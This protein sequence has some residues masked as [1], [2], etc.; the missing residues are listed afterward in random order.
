MYGLIGN[1]RREKLVI[2]YRVIALE[3]ICLYSRSLEI[4]R[5]IYPYGTGAACVCEMPGSFKMIAD[6]Q[7]IFY[8][9]SIFCHL[10]CCLCNIIFLVAYRAKGKP[11]RKLL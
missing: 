4:H 11:F 10:F 9:D 3:V 5:D 2:L 1:R 8:H 7:R 6:G